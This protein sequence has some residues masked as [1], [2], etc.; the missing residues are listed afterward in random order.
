MVESFSCVVSWHT[1]IEPQLAM[2]A[3]KDQSRWKFSWSGKFT[4]DDGSPSPSDDSNPP[5]MANVRIKS[6]D[7]N[8]RRS[9][10]LPWGRY[11]WIHIEISLGAG[12][13]LR[14]M[15]AGLSELLFLKKFLQSCIQLLL[16]GLDPIMVGRTSRKPWAAQV[17]DF[18][19]PVH[20]LGRRNFHWHHRN[21]LQMFSCQSFFGRWHWTFNAVRSCPCLSSK[22]GSKKPICAVNIPVRLYCT[23]LHDKNSHQ[24]HTLPLGFWKKVAICEEKLPSPLAQAFVRNEGAKACKEDGAHEGAPDR[25]LSPGGDLHSTLGV[26]CA[27]TFNRDFC[28][29]DLRLFSQLRTKES[30]WGAL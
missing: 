15:Q 30:G 4:K 21:P 3:K 20:E 12:N 29:L 25:Y 16:E 13:V 28:R 23:Q 2:V 18:G 6:N 10:S 26:V 22:K 11:F 19:K 9:K 27:N 17:R 1:C 8:V 7:G 14:A 5:K 24:N